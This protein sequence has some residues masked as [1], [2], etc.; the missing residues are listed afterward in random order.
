[1]IAHPTPPPPT[2]EPSLRTV[3]ALMES[4]AAERGDPFAFAVSQLLSAVGYAQADRDP[5]PF[6]ELAAAC[7]RIAYA[8]LLG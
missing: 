5:L 1:M 3:A 7:H 8:W 6:A 4:A 2:P